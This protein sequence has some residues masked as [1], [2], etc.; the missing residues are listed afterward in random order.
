MP[1]MAL[2]PPLMPQLAK[3]QKVLP[4]GPGWV[5]EPKWDGFRVIVFKTGDSVFLQSRNN[6][7]LNRYFPE[8]VSQ[9]AALAENRLVVDAEIV[10]FSGHKQRFDLLSQRV[11]PAE[12]RV[13]K[14]STETPA[15]LIAFDLLENDEGSFLG[16]PFHA[17]RKRL[18]QTLES[19]WLT[20]S[21][22]EPSVARSWLSPGYEG[23]IAKQ[24][25]APYKP[26]ERVGMVKVKRLRTADTV[27]VGLRLAKDS[28]GLGSLILALYDDRGEL[29]VVGHSSGFNKKLKR[30]LLAAVEP[31]RT[32]E[33]H[34]PEPS[35][36][37]QLQSPWEKLEPTLVCEVSFDHVSEGRI[38]HGAS[39][40]RFR[41]DKDPSECGMEQLDG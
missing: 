3:S 33:T 24:A 35:R 6:R 38:R 39:F 17:R 23:V 32:H 20:P 14:L 25:D 11:H 30:D 18:E 19:H 8:V 15:T 10:V 27:V 28:S 34:T 2:E 9:V 21:S 40:M 1:P 7:G 5:Y 4:E 12:S 13:R 22:S 37:S 26:G 41:D 31:Y 29:S 36:F 16:E